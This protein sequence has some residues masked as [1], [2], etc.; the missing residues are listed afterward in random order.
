MRQ[1]NI[2]PKKKKKN[3]LGKERVQEREKRKTEMESETEKEEEKEEEIKK[4]I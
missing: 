2:V 3:V 4:V 1:K